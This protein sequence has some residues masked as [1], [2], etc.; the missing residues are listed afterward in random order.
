MVNGIPRRMN[1]RQLPVLSQSLCLALKNLTL[2]LTKLISMTYIKHQSPTSNPSTY[3][4]LMTSI[5]L[6][7]QTKIRCFPTIIVSIN[8]TSMI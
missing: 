2:P 5:A 6:L 1:V 4:Q 7:M 8:S 3:R